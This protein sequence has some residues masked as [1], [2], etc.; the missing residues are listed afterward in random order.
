MSDRFRAWA[1]LIAA[2]AAE[3]TATVLLGSTEQFTRLLP[4]VA[5][6]AGY[7]LSFAFLAQ[8]LR[9]LPVSLAYAM[10]SGIGT[11]TVALIGV[12][13]L[14]EELSV[15][16]VGGVALIVAGVVVLNVGGAHGDAGARSAEP[17]LAGDDLLDEPPRRD[18]A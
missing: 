10:W 9:T 14:G 12:L 15:A 8:A 18:P 7:V 1:F 4:S 17:V 13:A 16:K 2:I 5:V 3:I 6:I 11:A